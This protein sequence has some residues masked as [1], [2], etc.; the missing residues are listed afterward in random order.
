MA[1]TGKATCE[2]QTTLPAG[3]EDL[4]DIVAALAPRAAPLLDCLGDGPWPATGAHHQWIEDQLLPN[5][6]LVAAERP[7]KAAR[8]LIAV[9]NPG[10]FRPGDRV[11]IA[12]RP[13]VMSVTAVR[14]RPRHILCRCGRR[15]AP[16]EKLRPGQVLH[17]LGPEPVGDRRIAAA[18]FTRRVRRGNHTL[19]LVASVPC[20]EPRRKA[21]GLRRGLR[22]LQ[23]AVVLGADLPDGG[24]FAGLLDLI[25]T[26]VFDAGGA[27]PTRRRLERC[28]AD[29]CRRSCSQADTLVAGD[30][31]RGRLES[32]ARGV[33]GAMALCRV[34]A[35]PDVPRDMVVML[36]RSRAAV[37]PLAGRSFHYAPGGA[38]AGRI[39]GQYTLE[40]RGEVAH[41]LLRGLRT[42]TRQRR[43]KTAV[44]R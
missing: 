1:F 28:L 44:S 3:A 31:W 4:S 9:E 34:V 36:D 8:G 35:C 21:A 22:D 11:R 29:L 37:P 14:K 19:E 6:D 24:R 7:G 13:E 43:R 42:T 16:G 23:R 12:G 18:R 5:T 17:I 40:L 25:R 20:D 26:N 33:H 32:L 39:I 38:G 2:L 30:A 41:G 10:R 27:E 15:A